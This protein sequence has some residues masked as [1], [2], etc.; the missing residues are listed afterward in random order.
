MNNLIIF[1]ELMYS[2]FYEIMKFCIKLY[3]FRKEQKR[4]FL[5]FSLLNKKLNKEIKS[6]EEIHIKKKKMIQ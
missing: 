6:T 3:N 1:I 4:S 2:F 5:H